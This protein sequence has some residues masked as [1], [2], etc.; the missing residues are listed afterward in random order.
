MCC[1][2][3]ACSP[4]LQCT[5]LTVD[6]RAKGMVLKHYP[7]LQGSSSTL[8]N[9]EKHIFLYL[10]H[11]HHHHQVLPTMQLFLSTPLIYHFVSFHIAIEQSHPTTKNFLGCT[12]RVLRWWQSK[13]EGNYASLV[14][15]LQW[16]Q[17]LNE[18]VLLLLLL[19]CVSLFV[20]LQAQVCVCVCVCGILCCSGTSHW[21]S[22]PCTQAL[23]QD[24]SASALSQ[25]LVCM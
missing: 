5:L 10:G 15:G 14:E 21:T 1:E 2:Q 9:S 20:F 23:R 18:Q 4:C 8:D 12:K 3:D 6:S 24:Y 11:C 13:P 22:T 16:L 25:C 19:F 17:T 7:A